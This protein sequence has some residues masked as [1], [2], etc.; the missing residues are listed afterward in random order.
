MINVET[1]VAVVTVNVTKGESSFEL[2]AESPAVC[3]EMKISRSDFPSDFVFGVGSS[4][5][6]VHVS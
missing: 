4:A 5:P 3:E 1:F 6:Q 2:I